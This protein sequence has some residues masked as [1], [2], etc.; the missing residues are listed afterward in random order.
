MTITFI[1]NS[2]QAHGTSGTTPTVAYT[3]NVTSGNLLVLCVNTS[4][5]SGTW[6]VSDTLSNTWN[7]AGSN[8]IN[9]NENASIWYAISSSGG[10]NTITWH[11]SAGGSYTIICH[12]YSGVTGTSPLD[13]AKGGTGT[14]TA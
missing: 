7:Q 1:T 4:A 11:Q 5:I 6:S 3:S 8:N 2:A 10:A 14:G 13:D 9:G 12:E